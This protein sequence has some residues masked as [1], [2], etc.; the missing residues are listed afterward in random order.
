MNAGVF[1]EIF[2][3]GAVE[4]FFEVVIPIGVDNRAV[5]DDYSFSEFHLANDFE[6][7]KGLPETHFSIPEEFIAV[8]EVVDGFADGGVLFGAENN[9]VAG[10]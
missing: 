5:G 3:A 4:N 6:G 9:F 8:L 1:V 7:A 2:I 10:G